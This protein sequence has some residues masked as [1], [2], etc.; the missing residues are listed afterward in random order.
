MKNLHRK[1]EDKV[2]SFRDFLISTCR[3]LVRI[4]S[5][6]QPP[7]GGEYECQKLVARYFFIIILDF[8]N[9]D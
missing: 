6:N 8:R 3:E 2:D 1:I 5:I 9:I 4:P 7:S